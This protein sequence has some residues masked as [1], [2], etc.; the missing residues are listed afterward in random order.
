M[1][2]VFQSS[3]RHDLN[4]NLPDISDPGGATNISQ[5]MTG[6][7]LHMKLGYFQNFMQMNVL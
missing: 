7:F 3:A 6:T 4:A 1:N 5:Y 2:C